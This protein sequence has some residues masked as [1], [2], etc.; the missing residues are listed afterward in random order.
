[1]AKSTGRKLKLLII[2]AEK[3]SDWES[4]KAI[5]SGLTGAYQLLEETFDVS[6]FNVPGEVS[7][8]QHKSFKKVS[9]V[10]SLH[11]V[12]VEFQP[13]RLIFIDHLPHPYMLL[14]AL[15]KLDAHLSLPEVI[16]HVYGDF[17]YYSAEW[18][19]MGHLLIRN[20]LKLICSSQKQTALVRSFFSPE[21]GQMVETLFFPVDRRQFNFDPKARAVTRARLGLGV[22]DRLVIYT[23]RLSLQKNITTLIEEFSKVSSE[24]KNPPYLCLAGLFDDLGAALHGVITPNGYYFHKIQAALNALPKK[25]AARIRFLGHLSQGK[26]KDLYC[27][28]DVFTSLSLYH[29]E[30]FGMSVAEALA[31]GLPCV[32][33]DWGGYSTFA[34]ERYASRAV[35]VVLDTTGILLSRNSFRTHLRAALNQPKKEKEKLALS[36]LFLRDFSIEAAAK[37]LSGILLSSDPSPYPAAGGLFRGFMW[38]LDYL[39]GIVQRDHPTSV[40]FPKKGAFYES[41]YSSYFTTYPEMKNMKWN[42]SEDLNNWLYDYLTVSQ[43]KATNVVKPEAKDLLKSFWP[44]CEPYY[45][46]L[47]PIFLFEGWQSGLVSDGKRWQARDGVLPLYYFLQTVS[48]KDFP[49]KLWIHR[50]FAALVPP[51]WREAI[52]FYEA[53]SKVQKEDLDQLKTILIAGLMSAPF[54]NRD[55]FE[56]QLDELVKVI[57]PARLSKMKILVFMPFRGSSVFWSHL[58]EEVYMEM[59]LL[60]AKKLGNHVESISW[61]R[62]DGMRDLKDCLY[63]EMNKGWI[64]KDSSVQY[65]ALSR[66]ASHFRNLQSRPARGEFVDLSENH[67]LRLTDPEVLKTLNKRDHGVQMRQESLY[68]KMADFLYKGRFNPVFL[69]WYQAYCKDTFSL[70]VRD[71][72]QMSGATAVR[73]SH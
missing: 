56:E 37:K 68:S 46:P 57:G 50:D 21:Q 33:S 35:P 24:L 66:G 7:N 23:G 8:T 67:R 36:Q 63:C 58:Q 59:P 1:M 70:D 62:L 64:V 32:L 43:R 19:K 49:A 6:W 51:Q 22:D 39:S 60:L 15:K 13:D 54:I 41:V 73:S 29:D 16:V 10:I 18:K 11:K 34:Q 4:C 27:A 12:M 40:F 17:T 71:R 28:A 69:D 20:R 55:E 9:T 31:C 38:Q 61:N 42:L 45:S 48:P 53:E 65:L 30:D 44:F 3:P 2:R 72:V 5:S 26:L 25:I 52:G 14:S 47:Q